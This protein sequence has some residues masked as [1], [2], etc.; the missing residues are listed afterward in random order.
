MKEFQD[1]YERLERMEGEAQR[2]WA[3]KRS[4]ADR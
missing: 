2:D 3:A 4:Q 1:C